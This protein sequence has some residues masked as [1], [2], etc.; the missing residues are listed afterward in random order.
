MFMTQNPYAQFGNPA[1]AGAGG[2]IGA[3]G[4]D[5][6][7]APQRTSA[8]AIMSLV[9]A[10]LCFIPGAAPLAIIFGGAAILFISSSKGR[11]GGLG[12]AISGVL[13]GLF[14]TVCW[15][16]VVIGALSVVKQFGAGFTG[17]SSNMV[18]ALEAGDYATARTYFDPSLDKAVTDQQ[19]AEFVAAYQADVGSFQ[20]MP[21]SLWDYVTSFIDMGQTMQ[22]YQGNRQNEIPIPTTFSNT[23][24]LVII[25]I[26]QGSG[27]MQPGGMLPK[28]TNLGV[29]NGS[30]SEVWLL[31]P[32]TFKPI[33]NSA[34]GAGA[35][36]PGTDP[37]NTPDADPDADNDDPAGNEGGA[38]GGGATGGG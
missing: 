27:Q 8:M 9:L 14:F 29:W 32:S 19:L 11:L 3:G 21:E 22:G 5:Q 10:L 31:D 7:P 34:A 4:F 2:S 35:T 18:T 16:L 24:A 12:M 36:A 17:P 30:T 33:D 25:K 38:A 1:P 26:P 20:K 13:I 37:A 6:F 28:I 23:M 15:L